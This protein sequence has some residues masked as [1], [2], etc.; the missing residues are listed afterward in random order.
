MEIYEKTGVMKCQNTGVL[1]YWSKEFLHPEPTLLSF[2]FTDQ[3]GKHSE[4]FS[5][6]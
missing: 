6:T 4:I 1:E 2:T 3:F 5:V